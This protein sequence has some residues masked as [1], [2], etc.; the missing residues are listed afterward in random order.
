MQQQLTA[1]NS[2][3][4]FKAN[5]LICLRGSCRRLWCFYKFKIVCGN[6]VSWP[7]KNCFGKNHYKFIKTIAKLWQSNKAFLKWREKI[8]CYYNSTSLKKKGC[9]FY[10]RGKFKRWKNGKW[11]FVSVICQLY[12][13]TNHVFCD[14][15]CDV[16]LNNSM[17]YVTLRLMLIKRKVT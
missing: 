13:F 15:F 16:F 8:S 9:I 1:K 7:S 12:W 14:V 5:H 3:Y 2:N 17:T 11:Q 10:F 4:C 6:S